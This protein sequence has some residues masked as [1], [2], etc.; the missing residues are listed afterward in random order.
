MQAVPAPKIAPLRHRK[1]ELSEAGI[2]NPRL[3]K[4]GVEWDEK[5]LLGDE[6]P[7]LA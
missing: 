2:K 5:E 7:L 1:H 3:G 4:P 6:Q